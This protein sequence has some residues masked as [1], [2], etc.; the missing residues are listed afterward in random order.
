LEE[1]AVENSIGQIDAAFSQAGK[2]G[3]V[4]LLNFSQAPTCAG[5]VALENHVYPDDQVASLI[6]AHF[7]ALRIRS[8]SLP[9]ARRFGVVWTPTFIVAE[10]DGTER[11][12]VVGYL[13]VPEFAAQLRLALAKVAFGRD[14]FGEAAHAFDVIVREHPMTFATAEA[15]Y[16][17]GVSQ[18]KQ[19]KDRTYLKSTAET[20]AKYWPARSGPSRHRYGCKQRENQTNTMGQLDAISSV[21]RP[22]S[23]MKTFATAGCNAKVGL[24]DEVSPT[25]A[26]GARRSPQ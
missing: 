21:T 7:V 15:R 19:D 12:R 5:S 4:P 23:T 16:W 1:I 11:H 10:S 25:R 24:T 6:A 17:H 3:R 13:P 8:D 26:P 18:Y 20:L 22:A 14:Q 2:D 9:D